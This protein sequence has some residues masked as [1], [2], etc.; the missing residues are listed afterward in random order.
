[1]RACA[2]H[3]YHR[4]RLPLP[5]PLGRERLG[6]SNAVWYQVMIRR[7]IGAQLRI[8]EKLVGAFDRKIGSPLIHFFPLK[9]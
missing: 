7:P 5:L 6:E 3:G 2:P 1:V 8:A 9:L 4:R